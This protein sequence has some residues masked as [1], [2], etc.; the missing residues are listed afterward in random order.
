M[1]SIVRV[2]SATMR[3][4]GCAPTT[5]TCSSSAG[6]ITGAGV[7]LDAAS[8]GLRTAL[9]ERHDFA[10]GTQLAELEARARR[11]P[12]PRPAR[13]PP[14]VR[15]ARTNASASSRTRRIWC[16]CSRSSFPCSRA[17]VRIDRRLAPVLGSALWM[18]DVT[19][20]LRIGKRHHE[21]TSTRPSPTSRRSTATGSSGA[22]VL[23]DAQ[24][25]DARLTLDDRA[26]RACA[27]G[28]VVDELRRGRRRSN[29]TTGTRRRRRGSASAS[30]ARRRCRA[31]AAS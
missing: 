30:T 23:Y 2:S 25:D 1:P 28:A 19:G 8:R 15:G 22:Y 9:V 27:Y 5:S 31:R 12:V 3:C 14:G 20:G 29:G 21:I 6:G 7:A 13:V 17:A 18:Y 11:A 4:S 16:A 10:S 24:A 26:H